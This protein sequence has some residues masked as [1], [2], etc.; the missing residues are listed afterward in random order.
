MANRRKLIRK[1][2]REVLLNQTD[3]GSKVYSNLS[4]PHWGENTPEIAIFT[5][6]E[7]IEDLGT[8][9][10][11]YKRTLEL[12]IEI[13]A[14]GTETPNENDGKLVEDIVDDIA[15][16]VEAALEKDETLGEIPG[17]DPACVYIDELFLNNVEFQFEIG[18]KPT[19]SA[20]L[21]YSVIYYEARPKNLELQDNVTDFEGVDARWDVGHHDSPPNK[22]DKEAEDIFE[23][24]QE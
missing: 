1:R 2:V 10:K 19:A 7:T 9:P 14:E 18:Q 5:R 22:D 24:E 15:E 23:M 16:Q 4:S 6:S 17:S 21:I 12:A 20:R 11:E 3:A 13:V 8:A